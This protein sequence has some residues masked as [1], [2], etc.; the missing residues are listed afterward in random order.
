MRSRVR[1]LFQSIREQVPGG[2]EALPLFAGSSVD[3]RNVARHRRGRRPVLPRF[4][5]GRIA[6]ATWSLLGGTLR[7]LAGTSRGTTASTGAG[8]AG[9]AR[10]TPRPRR[11]D[12]LGD[13]LI[14]REDSPGDL[15]GY[16]R[17]NRCELHAGQLAIPPRT[18][19]VPRGDLARHTAR[20]VAKST[21]PSPRRACSRR[22]PSCRGE[23][24][25]SPPKSRGDP[26]SSTTGTGE[27]RS[28][29]RRLGPS[30][31]RWSVAPAGQPD[32]LSRFNAT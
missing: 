3:S 13:I 10:R 15:P 1:R 31:P 2:Q 8:S 20:T 18:V 11:R 6:S 19:A 23:L 12:P 30:R 4:G 22:R 7:S 21:W 24:S 9:P 16:H 5:R 14:P 26:R 17:G 25:W 28:W 32:R 29:S 27:R